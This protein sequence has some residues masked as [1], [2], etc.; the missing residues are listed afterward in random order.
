[1]SIFDNWDSKLLSIAVRVESI[2]TVITPMV[3]Y[4]LMVYHMPMATLVKIDNLCADLFWAG[5]KHKIT[6]TKLRTL[7]NEGGIRLKTLW[8]LE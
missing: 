5:K 4:W 3:L 7:T 1:M 2:Q 8:N 6:W